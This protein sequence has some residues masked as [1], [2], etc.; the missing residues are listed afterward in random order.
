MTSTLPSRRPTFSF[1]HLWLLTLLY[2]GFCQAEGPIELTPIKVSP[3]VWYFQGE[4]GAAS[5]ENKGY[6]SN[7]GFIVTGDQVVVFD[8]LGTP[9]LGESMIR[10]I[11]KITRLPIKLA[12]VSHYHA[13]HF[14]G[15]QAF[16]AVGTK[17]LAHEQSKIYLASN[18]AQDRLDQRR[19]DLTPWVDERTRLVPP[20][21]YFKGNLTLR[22]GGIELRIIDIHG[23]HAPDDIMLHIPSD[24]VLFAGDLF[25]SGRLPFVGDADTERWLIALDHMLESKPQVVIPGHGEASAN[26]L[27]DIAATREYLIFLRERM[28]EAVA[29]LI[30]FDEAYRR[31]DWSRYAGKRAFDAANRLNAYNV[32]IQMEQE[33]L[34]K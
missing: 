2:I 11:R 3:H 34:R 30:P 22:R 32:Y 33:S 8:S 7:A 1:R 28:G 29:D 5:Q 31:T 19:R 17:V 10:A 18:T 4:S 21:D 20:D 23:S 6:M 13:D 12:I 15:L 25:F 26:P 27:Q 16:K 9:A 24:G 14:Y